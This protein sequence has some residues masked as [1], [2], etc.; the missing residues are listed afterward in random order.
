MLR[1]VSFDILF[2]FPG[3]TLELTSLDELRLNGNSLANPDFLAQLDASWH[4][5]RCPHIA[6]SLPFFGGWFVYLGY[7]LA[8]QIEPV[9]QLPTHHDA[10]PIAFATRIPA[11]LI[12]DHHNDTLT[13]VAEHGNEALLAAMIADLK[14]TLMLGKSHALPRP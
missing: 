1:S 7:E 2:A 9:L 5:D 14:R 13:L 3:E 4:A 8:G 6:T 10:L 12:C 11:A